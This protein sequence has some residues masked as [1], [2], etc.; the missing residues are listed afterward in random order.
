MQTMDESSRKLPELYKKRRQFR[1]FVRINSESS[2]KID[3]LMNSFISTVRSVAATYGTEE[4]LYSKALAF[5]NS[6]FYLNYDEKIIF[7]IRLLDPTLKMLSLYNSVLDEHNIV[8]TCPRT[9]ENKIIFLDKEIEEE[10]KK[11]AIETFGFYDASLIKYEHI[12]RTNVLLADSQE[13]TTDVK[14]NYA[15]HVSQRINLNEI[16]LRVDNEELEEIMEQAN[17][18]L[19]MYPTPSLNDLV[20]QLLFESGELTAISFRNQLIFIMI[21]LDRDLRYKNVYDNNY[22]FVTIKNKI[23]QI[24]GCYYQFLMDLELKY[25]KDNFEPNT[26]PQR[27]PSYR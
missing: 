24:F 26:V 5:V 13:K 4:T 20:F 21:V 23:S 15:K 10:L 25:A 14:I 1:H 16:D 19:K 9:Y 18:Y 22:N 12:Y 17:D 2:K 27:V 8:A 3:S 11:R 6:N 7:L